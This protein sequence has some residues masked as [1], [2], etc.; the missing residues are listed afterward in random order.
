MYII[1]RRQYIYLEVLYTL[2]QTLGH[3]WCMVWWVHFYLK[4]PTAEGWKASPSHTAG[5]LPVTE[6]AV[7]VGPVLCYDWWLPTPGAR[8]ET[9][10]VVVYRCIIDNFNKIVSSKKHPSATCFV[11]IICNCGRTKTDVMEISHSLWTEGRLAMQK[12]ILGPF[13]CYNVVSAFHLATQALA[14]QI[15]WLIW[16]P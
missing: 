16:Q 7:S 1:A 10:F 12:L 14:N 2:T 6:G 5:K 13:L 11:S 4:H 15:A 9:L 8:E 3:F